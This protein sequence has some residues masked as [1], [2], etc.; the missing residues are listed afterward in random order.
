MRRDARCGK[1]FRAARRGRERA[2]SR[3]DAP[4]ARSIGRG[5][6]W[7]RVRSGR[8]LGRGTEGE[9]M[10]S[11]RSTILS[12]AQ[13]ALAAALAL[14]TSS[15]LHTQRVRHEHALALKA[16]SEAD[17]AHA[18]ADSLRAHEPEYVEGESAPAVPEAL[19]EQRP[20]A[21]SP[22]HVWIA[23]QHTRSNGEWV[24][25]PG[26]YS[27]PPRADVV[28]VPGHWVAHLH[29]YVWIAGAWR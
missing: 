3:Q 21:P 1:T 19:Q 14:S 27:L 24:W 5:F 25:V 29:G 20:T 10:S 4:P 12:C 2:A 15:C 26:H 22:A 28:W 6:I 9:L 23:G 7:P 8:A 17:L 16:E 13:L 11:N 18:Q